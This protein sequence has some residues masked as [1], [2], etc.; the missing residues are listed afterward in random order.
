MDEQRIGVAAF[1]DGECLTGADRDDMNVQAGCGLEDRQDAANQPR[2]LSR[3]CRAQGNEP[4]VN[5]Y[6]ADLED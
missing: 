6:S 4:L 2:I 5:L 3:G 1:A